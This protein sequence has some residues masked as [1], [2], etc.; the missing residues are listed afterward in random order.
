M[1]FDDL[2]ESA[3]TLLNARGRVIGDGLTKLAKE[4]AHRSSA[5]LVEAVA[6]APHEDKP[7]V[8]LLLARV[9]LEEAV[10]TRSRELF[11]RLTR[12]G[13]SGD[14]IPWKD[15]SHGTSQ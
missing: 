15:L 8:G 1:L 6:Q 14:R 3:R 7:A 4:H 11:N 12:P 13:M 2:G 10:A 9:A 5:D